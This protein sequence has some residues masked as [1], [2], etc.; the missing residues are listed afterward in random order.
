MTASRSATPTGTPPPLLAACGTAINS[1]AHQFTCALGQDPLGSVYLGHML[2]GG[3]PLDVSCGM[4]LSTFLPLFR[5]CFATLIMWT[6]ALLAL[7]VGRLWGRGG[8]R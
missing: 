7:Q 1:Q 5:L 3:E 4:C 8:C 2:A 6:T